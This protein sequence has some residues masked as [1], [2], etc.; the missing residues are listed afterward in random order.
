MQNVVEFA[1]HA[2]Y[3]NLCLFLMLAGLN[4]I[5]SRQFRK[6]HDIDQGSLTHLNVGGR[7][8]LVGLRKALLRHLHAK[9]HLVSGIRRCD[10]RLQFINRGLGCP[11]GHTR[12]QHA[13]QPEWP[14]SPTDSLPSCSKCRPAPQATHAYSHNF[15]SSAPAPEADVWP[16]T[17][18]QDTSHRPSAGRGDNWRMPFSHPANGRKQKRAENT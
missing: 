5:V 10:A 13:K 8:E 16:A 4:G 12:R 15:I 2:A 7:I 14:R 1:C 11:E 18:V 3:G 9:V 17:P 6:T